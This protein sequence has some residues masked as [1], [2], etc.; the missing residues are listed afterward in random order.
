MWRHLL[1]RGLVIAATVAILAGVFFIAFGYSYHATENRNFAKLRKQA[2]LDCTI[3]PYHCAVKEGSAERITSLKASGADID[4]LDRF[5]NSP[6]LYAINWNTSLV[7]PLLVLGANPN[8]P[9]GQGLTPLEQSLNLNDFSLAEKLISY[10]ADPNARAE[11]DQKRYL[12]IL[13][14]FIIQKNERAASFLVQHGA[15]IGLRDGYG[16]DACERVRMYQASSTFP[17]CKDE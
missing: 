13:T 15:N 5:G 14:D 16:Y 10:G 8:I 12:T 11:G 6:L 17:F 7:E 3:M 4:S 9:N 2:E 1:I